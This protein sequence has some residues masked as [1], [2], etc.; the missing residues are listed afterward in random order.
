M[1]PIP[2]KPGLYRK[3]LLLF[4]VGQIFQVISGLAGGFGMA[5]YYDWKV[6]LVSNAFVPVLITGK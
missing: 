2:Q 4:Q 6:G 3:T 5:V 1:T